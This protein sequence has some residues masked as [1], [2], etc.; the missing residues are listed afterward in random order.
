MPLSG[1]TSASVRWCQ[2][3]NRACCSAHMLR[4]P[5]RLPI[6]PRLVRVREAGEADLCLHVFA[7]LPAEL[8]CSSDVHR[9]ARAIMDASS[10]PALARREGAVHLRS[11]KVVICIVER[12]VERCVD[13]SM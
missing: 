13:L 11:W 8:V 1:G 7:S 3:P 4:R 2:Q 12:I 5:R 6:S 9:G 10:L